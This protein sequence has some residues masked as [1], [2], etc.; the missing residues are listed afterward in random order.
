M[1]SVSSALYE[2]IRTMSP[3]EKGYF[4]K[5]L[6]L[7]KSKVIIEELFDFI[8][9]LE[10]YD[11]TIV[12]EHFKDDNIVKQLSRYKN[13]LYN[14]IMSSLRG[15]HYKESQHLRELTS[16]VQLLFDRGLFAQCHR[17]I[18]LAKKKAYKHGCYL[19]LLGLVS[20]ER[21]V[22]YS[23]FP[24]GKLDDELNK[25]SLEIEKVFAILND[26][27]AYHK[28]N[29]KANVKVLTSSVDDHLYSYSGDSFKKRFECLFHSPLLTADYQ[30]LSV[31][32]QFLKC[33]VNSTVFGGLNNLDKVENS[34]L[35]AIELI[36]GNISIFQEYP[37]YYLALIN[38]LGVV[39]LK[40]NAFEN[41]FLISKRVVPQEYKQEYL[42]IKAYQV[43]MNLQMG[44]MC[45]S[46][47][48]N[49]IKSKYSDFKT[50]WSKYGRSFDP[51]VSKAIAFNFYL[52]NHLY[53]RYPDANH[54][55]N[56]V[57]EECDFKL[58]PDISL[59]AYLGSICLHYDQGNWGIVE[60]RVR[61]LS[62]NGRFA[63]KIWSNISN[64]FL[65][66]LRNKNSEAEGFLELL[67]TIQ[68]AKSDELKMSLRNFDFEIW[69]KWKIYG[70][71]FSR[72]YLAKK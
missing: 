25:I 51:P 42:I 69:L 10:K 65:R 23:V 24:L 41:A 13:L 47:D 39:Y 36:E 18:K 20:L 8:E 17:R 30:P 3:N 33:R 22:V 14:S 44:A 57:L 34:L 55:S 31:M 58:R 43:Q 11:E 67:S 15:Y 68:K 35:E 2:L 5:C 45:Q 4:K 54:F 7:H 70:G 66:T 64:R 37:D 48:L 72:M 16:E 63:D 9:A 61:S 12:K 49:K 56:Y 71:Q 32:A 52:Y 19:E 1:S 46:R 28:I 21:R 38:N 29:A 59:G 27:N 40:K 62:R 60:S 50:I 6:S 26:L 53:A